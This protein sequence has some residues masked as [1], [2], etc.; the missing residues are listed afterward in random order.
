MSVR[1]S[2]MSTKEVTKP[3]VKKYL[4]ILFWLMLA[5]YLYIGASFLLDRLWKR[6]DMPGERTACKLQS[7]AS[8]DHKHAATVWF[9]MR[10]SFNL[11]NNYN[12]WV[13]V[14]SV[15]ERGRPV[16]GLF[17][18]SCVSCEWESNDALVIYYW[19]TINSDHSAIHEWQGVKIRWVA[20]NGPTGHDPSRMR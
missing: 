20:V 14:G 11:V 18:S 2:P 8:P 15:D 13:E 10:K 6:A 17:C 19:G 9:K 4:I 7:Y 1:S 5:G 12:T 16:F 3:L